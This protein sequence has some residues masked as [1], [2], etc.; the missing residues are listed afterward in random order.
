MKWNQWPWSHLETRS[1]SYVD[2]LAELLVARAKGTASPAAVGAASAVEVASGFIAR[3]LSLAE[4]ENA[5]PWQSALSGPFWAR[6]GRDLVRG[7]EHTALIETEPYAKLTAAQGAEIKGSWD[8]DTWRYV[9]T[10]PGPS[11]SAKVRA[12]A[13]EVVHVRYAVEPGSP[14]QGVGPIQS[15]SLPARVL[16]EVEQLLGDEAAG[17]RGRVI[18][19][20]QTPAPD[21]EGDDDTLDGLQKDV[22]GLAGGVALVESQRNNWGGGEQGATAAGDWVP[23]SVSPEPAV[24]LV[25]V[26]Q[27]A[28]RAVLS[29]AGLPLALFESGSDAGAREAYRRALHTCLNPLVEIA[30]AELREKLDLPGLS[31]SLARLSASDVAGRARAFRLFT[32]GGIEAPEARRLAGLI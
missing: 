31:V 22:S 4:V 19:I 7:G 8:P 24:A 28:Y 25:Q 2:R 27:E 21:S 10:M 9:L 13:A 32:E 12:E 16:A 11:R 20:P 29:A 14:W 15:A 18:P 6:L 23:K 17:P 30:V 3:C 1:E 26:W 5:G